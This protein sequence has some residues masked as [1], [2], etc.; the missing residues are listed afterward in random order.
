MI[1][2]YILQFYIRTK[3]KKYITLENFFIKVNNIIK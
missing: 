3:P 2:M 1:D